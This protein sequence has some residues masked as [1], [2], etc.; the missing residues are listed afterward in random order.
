MT[1]KGLDL[2]KRFE[3]CKLTAYRC[4]AGIWTIGY[5]H[6]QGVYEGKKIT[7][8]EAER[9]L[10]S[11]LAKFETGVRNILGSEAN[12]MSE[13]KIDALVSLAFNIGLGAFKNS[14]L[15]K[16]IK[17][18]DGVEAVCNQ[19]LRW[20]FVGKMTSKGLLRRRIAEA[21]RYSGLKIKVKMLNDYDIE[22]SFGG[23]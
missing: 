19:F 3:G 11:D 17:Q 4:P 14:T 13:N 23:E 1:K 9:L 15:V 21:E 18:A 5:G 8:E 2:I 7:E 16:K 22:V 12:G 20:R 6:T 10:A